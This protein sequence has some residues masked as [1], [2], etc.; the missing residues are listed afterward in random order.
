L[1]DSDRQSAVQC[2]SFTLT[3]IRRPFTKLRRTSGTIFAANRDRWK[4]A[5]HNNVL[6]DWKAIFVRATNRATFGP[7]ETG[8][9]TRSAG[10]RHEHQFCCTAR[11]ARRSP[12]HRERQ[13]SGSDNASNGVGWTQIEKADPWRI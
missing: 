4:A 3:R 6:L 9:R 5:D 8:A 1:I 10:Q 11:L 2:Y 7:L 13:A 12:Y